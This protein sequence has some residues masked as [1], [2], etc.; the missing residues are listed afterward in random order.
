MSKPVLISPK[1]TQGI[2]TNHPL[3]LA[4]DSF[5]NPADPAV[6]MIMGLGSQ[7]TA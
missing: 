1:Y 7:M 4:Y 6:L 2:A 5:G 3:K